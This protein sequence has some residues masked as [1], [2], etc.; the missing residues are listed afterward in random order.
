MAYNPSSVL[1]HFNRAATSYDSVATLQQRYLTAMVAHLADEL[2][3]EAII[4]DIGC[5][6]GMLARLAAKYTLGWHITGVDMAAAMCQQASKYQSLTL[7]GDLQAIPL[8]D[9]YADLTMC[10]FVLQWSNDPVS[11]IKE[12]ARITKP[13]GTIAV[14]TF[15]QDTL[16]ELDQTCQH[17]GIPSKTNHFHRAA[18]Y[19]SWFKEAGLSLTEAHQDHEVSYYDSVWGLFRSLKQMGA[20]NS[21]RSTIKGLGSRRELDSIHHIYTEQFSG[22]KGITAS[23][24]VGRWLWKKPC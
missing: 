21:Q 14:A 8:A 12:L 18:D 16:K 19:E 1:Q 11:A 15:L 20:T 2:N 23:W 9:D 24:E 17:I 22:P 3:H 6:T 4:A 13:G 10:A 5:G 7:Q